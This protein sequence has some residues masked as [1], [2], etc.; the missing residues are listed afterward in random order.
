MRLIGRWNA[1]LAAIGLLAV[2]TAVYWAG[3]TGPF[4]FDDFP[5][6]VDNAKVHA[7][8][9]DWVSLKRA[10][11]GF[12][13]GG[14]GRQLAMLTFAVN[15]AL[16]GLNPWGWKLGGL[17]VHLV[18]AY[19]VYLLCQ[20]LLTMAGVTRWSRA[21][22]WAVALLWAVH[23][24]QVSSVLYVVQRMETLALTFILLALLFYIKGRVAQREG[25]PGWG[26]IAACVPMLLLSL[27]CKETAALFPAYTLALELTLLGFAAT[28]VRVRRFWQWGYAAGVLVA[29][30]AFCVVVLPHYAPVSAYTSRNFNAWERVLTQLRVLPMYL[31][32]MLFPVLSKMTFYYDQ[33]APSRS[34]VSPWTTWAGGLLLLSLLGLAVWQRHAR[35]LFALGIFWF[36]ASHL[37]TSNVVPLE[38]VFEHRNY[39]ALLGILLSLADLVRRIPVRDGPAIK[40]AGI[41][42]I[43]LAV[44]F[45]GAVRAA[46][47][48]DRLLLA[49]DLASINPQSARAAHEL[50]VLYYEMSDGHPNSPFFSFARA[51]FERETKAPAASILAEQSL[52][53]MAA[54]HDEPV[55]PALWRRLQQRLQEQPITPQT[56]SA[57]F[58]LLDNRMKGVALDDDALDRSFVLMFNRVQMPPYSYA[59]VASHALKYSK[60]EPLARQLL[61]EAVEQS[62][63]TPDY[64]PILVKGL[65]TDGYDVLA[66]WVLQQAKARGIAP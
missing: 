38:L 57:L 27:G 40:I 6:L 36:F 30:V 65:R 3:L 49:T 60:N 14:T 59:Q 44:G 1:V 23:P 45:L 25:R 16:G 33:F 28:D 62:V 50:G 12:D 56:T 8:A 35:P 58:G 22:A 7:T 63:E 26:W 9:L 54:A 39:F 41:G 55:D 17:L 31:G 4:V 64:I 53:L 51:E 29:V 10:V 66:D 48:G 37:I 18:N 11:F 34:L 32:Q 13:P 43:V 21:G 5:A 15:H 47:W 24:L 20:R 46:T 61:L 42:A 52:I 2:V 19:L